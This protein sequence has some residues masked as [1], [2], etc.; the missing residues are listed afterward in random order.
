MPTV[1]ITSTATLS[2]ALIPERG[3]ATSVTVNGSQWA[4]RQTGPDDLS[5]D[6]A[7]AIPAGRSVVITY[8]ALPLPAID[9]SG[10]NSQ[11]AAKAS[12]SAVDAHAAAVATKVVP[13]DLAPYAL[14]S[15]VTTGLNAKASAAQLASLQS[16]V[17]GISVSGSAL[18]PTTFPAGTAPA[19]ALDLPN[20]RDYGLKILTAN[21]ALAF[22]SRVAN[23]TFTAAIRGGSGSAFVVDLS[24]FSLKGPDT[25]DWTDGQENIFSGFAY[26][27]T[28][29]PFLFC[30]LGDRVPV[31]PAA[32][33]IAFGTATANTQ[34]LTVSAP[35]GM[36]SRTLQVSIDGTTW[37]SPTGSF[38]GNVFTATGLT[39]S[40]LYYWRA[41]ATN[42]AGTSAYGSPVSG[43]TAA[44]ATLLSFAEAAF[45]TTVSVN[46]YRDWV[47]PTVSSGDSRTKFAAVNLIVRS[48]EGT[49]GD[50]VAGGV[51]PT[52]SGA[53]GFNTSGT[54]VGA[55]SSA[56]AEKHYQAVNVLNDKEVYTIPATGA[57]QTVRLITGAVRN[58]SFSVAGNI[59]VKLT[60]SDGS[61]AAVNITKAGSGVDGGVVNGAYDISFQSSGAGTL[62][63]EMGQGLW[64][65]Q[66]VALV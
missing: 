26:S 8:T 54:D 16:Q 57:V 49:L 51:W 60:L 61:A 47:K 3:A 11:L 59:L 21:I 30:S 50:Q 19:L 39:A 42:S 46:S 1:S 15:A 20:G 6:F 38:V 2:E 33:T 48:M 34:P 52:V 64:C 5:I 43:S 63:I 53:S 4:Y 18:T 24:A 56:T 13:A 12:Q 31:I 35:V 17:D 29:K 62:R 25:P 65:T 44:A 14:A 9:L 40:T 41:S 23:G 58:D 10:V 45:P 55:W 28:S 22:A 66:L 32:P 27:A 37:T 7:P 36:T